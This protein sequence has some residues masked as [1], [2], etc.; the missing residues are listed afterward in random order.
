[1]NSTVNNNSQPVTGITSL[2][3]PTPVR[4]KIHPCKRTMQQIARLG[5][6]RCIPIGRFVNQK[7]EIATISKTLV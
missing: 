6:N 3:A 5:E 7:V 2:M 1:M 4:K